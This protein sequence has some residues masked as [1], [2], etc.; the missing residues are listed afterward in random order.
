MVQDNHAFWAFDL[1][2]LSQIAFLEIAEGDPVATCQGK[3]GASAQL[4]AMDK[5]C[6]SM[7]E[8]M[9]QC[10]NDTDNPNWACQSWCVTGYTSDIYFWNL[11]GC[12]TSCL[13]PYVSTNDMEWGGEDQ[14]WSNGEW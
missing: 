4:C 2:L 11:V 10:G 1:C 5:S 3:C 12:Q 13:W 9:I 6:G 7:L 14:Q 8:C